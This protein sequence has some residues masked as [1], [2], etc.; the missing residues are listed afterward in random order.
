MISTFIVVVV[1]VC[2][3]DAFSLWALFTFSW[4]R[5][6]NPSNMPTPR[7]LRWVPQQCGITNDVT[8]A[9][10]PVKV[11]NARYTSRKL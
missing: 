11:V 6:S 5:S 7:M 2:S 8:D 3:Q 1:F 9:K 4:L 10:G